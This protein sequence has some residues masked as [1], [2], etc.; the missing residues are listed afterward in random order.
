[1]NITNKV[2]SEVVGVVSQ[3][4]YHPPSEPSNSAVTAPRGRQE[5]ERETHFGQC[6]VTVV[7]LSQET[8][9]K[10][11]ATQGKTLQRESQ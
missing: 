9:P 6:I 10:K 11:G 7:V 3:I 8:E 2:V 4:L 1:M 5:S